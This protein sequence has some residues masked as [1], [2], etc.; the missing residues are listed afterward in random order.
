M[1]SKL[2]VILACCVLAPAVLM[3]SAFGVEAAEV[4]LLV[5]NKSTLPRRIVRFVKQLPP[6]QAYPETYISLS[7]VAGANA[8]I[9]T[10]RVWVVVLNNGLAPD[11]QA[12]AGF[13]TTGL[14]NTGPSPQSGVTVTVTVNILKKQG[15][16]RLVL[17]IYKDGFFMISVANDIQRLGIRS[18]TTSA[19][20]MD[21][22]H[23]YHA[24]AYI[25]CFPRVESQVVSGIAEITDLRF[26]F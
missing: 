26:Q 4:R 1:R 18:Q 22:N 11:D 15:D 3:S 16:F 19:F 23:D 8:D 13:K 10:N 6:P 14:R 25:V 17:A 9:R 2:F 21:P 12:A 20:T 24:V 7:G 5:P